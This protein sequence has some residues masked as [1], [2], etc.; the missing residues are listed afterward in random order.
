M[1]IKQF[2]VPDLRCGKEHGKLTEKFTLSLSDGMVNRGCWERM[3]KVM[4]RAEKGEKLTLVFLG[5][6]ITQGCLAT[7][8]EKCYA[9][10]TYL[11]WKE[12]YPKAEIVYINAGIGGT[13]SQFG[14]ARADQDVLSYHPDLVFVEF[15]VNDENT[16]F[17]QETYEGLLR[18]L[19][20][21]ES[22]PAVMLIHN[23]Q[24]DVGKT[25]EEIHQELGNYYQLPCVSMKSTI[26]ARI[27]AGNF[28]SR[29]V[30]EDDLHP[31]DRGH[32]MLTDVIT[33]YLEQID[34]EKDTAEEEA[35]MPAPMTANAYEH[36]TRYQSKDCTPK[37]HGFLPDIREKD[38]YTDVY[39][40][41]WTAKEKGDEI[42]FSVEG[43]G[44]AVQFRQSVKKP[45]PIAKAILDGDEE[46]AVILDA[47]FELDWGDNLALETLLYHGE[48]KMHDLVIRIEERHE[49]DAVEFYLVS[50][51]A[52]Y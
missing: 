48:N 9:Y 35:A 51:I 34:K 10:L 44:I 45:A 37:M 1:L 25:A 42:H 30:T 14:I 32:R 20:G 38:Y 8:H 31:N 3:K 16:P 29:D 23:I 33:Y 46:H 47:N 6:S 21:D 24:Y 22:A 5:G 19:Y 40:G 18:H 27:M 41:G 11:W 52:S 15:S 43:S 26:Y 28:G 7:V 13:T 2:P 17:F 12:K 50:V 4:R 39:K 49:D 36:S